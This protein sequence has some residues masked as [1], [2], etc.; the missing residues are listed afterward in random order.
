MAS[1][2]VELV[3]LAAFAGFDS[4]VHANLVS[5]AASGRANCAADE[6]AFA[7]AG[8]GSD[9][10]SASCG[11]DDDLG[12]GV[13]A[14]VMAALGGNGAVMPIVALREGWES[15]EAGQGEAGEDFGC[16]HVVPL[17]FYC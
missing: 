11:T 13:V 15:E 4:L 1:A 10:G 3:G 2:G 14:V 8:E 9:G 16:V 17:S 6:G 7:A 12:T 5:D